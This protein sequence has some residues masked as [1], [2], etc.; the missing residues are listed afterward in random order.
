MHSK[1]R[2]GW[3]PAAARPFAN[4]GLIMATEKIVDGPAKDECLSRML[5]CHP[6]TF[7]VSGGSVEILID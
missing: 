7:V 2:E 3:T 4:Q 1:F 5:S 6:L